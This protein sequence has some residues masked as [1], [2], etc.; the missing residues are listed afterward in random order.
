MCCPSLSDCPLES[1]LEREN[2]P[3]LERQES[4]GG[5]YK[6]QGSCRHPQALG[7]S[8][9]LEN[10]TFLCNTHLY[11]H[12]PMQHISVF[13]RSYATHT[14]IHRK[15]LLPPFPANILELQKVI[16]HLAYNL[17]TSGLE[18][19]L[20]KKKQSCGSLNLSG[21]PTHCPSSQFCS[22]QGRGWVSVTAPENVRCNDVLGIEIVSYR[23][24]ESWDGLGWKTP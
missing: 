11:S 6:R 19:Y 17:F 22:I 13:P 3:E 23:I 14:F 2:S 12:V 4:L 24:R 10:P 5:S 9:S 1:Q 15:F 16:A 20:Y 8:Q 7:W 21:T 18:F